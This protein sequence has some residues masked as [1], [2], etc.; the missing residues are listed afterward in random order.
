MGLVYVI[1]LC[2]AGGACSNSGYHFAS[3]AKC[4]QSIPLLAGAPGKRVRVGKRSLYSLGLGTW[5][6]C[7]QE[8]RDAIPQLQSAGT[9]PPL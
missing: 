5:Y 3:S 4:E 9:P 7:R 8:P 2:V 1:Y 6:E